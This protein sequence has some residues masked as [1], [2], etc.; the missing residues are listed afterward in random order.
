MRRWVRGVTRGRVSHHGVMALTCTDAAFELPDAPF[1]LLR[2][3]LEALPCPCRLAS[4]L[5][6]DADGMCNALDQINRAHSHLH[7]LCGMFH[8]SK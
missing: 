5:A 2:D 4:R 6:F 8:G 3:S 7:R 1:A